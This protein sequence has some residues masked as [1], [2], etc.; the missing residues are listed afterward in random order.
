MGIVYIVGLL[1]GFLVQ[2]SSAV[3]S[4]VWEYTTV[5]RDH[6]S[7][8]EGARVDEGEVR[9]QGKGVRLLTVCLEREPLRR[10]QTHSVG[11][12]E[13]KLQDTVREGNLPQERR[14]IYE[15]WATKSHKLRTDTPVQRNITTP[16]QSP[17][18]S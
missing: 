15:D 2:R 9:M 10:K 11:G 13:A 16:T 1:H 18:A 14:Y 12:A 7:C 5:R 17:S 6:E 4:D 8:E 3:T